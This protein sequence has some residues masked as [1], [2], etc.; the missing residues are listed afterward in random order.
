MKNFVVLLAASALALTPASHAQ[1]KEPTGANPKLVEAENDS[2]SAPMSELTVA[3]IQ[4]ATVRNT[5]G[6]ELGQVDKV[7]AERS[8]GQIRLVLVSVGGFLGIGDKLVAVPWSALSGAGTDPASLMLDAEKGT[9]T[10]APGVEDTVLTDVAYK[11]WLQWGEDYFSKD[12]AP[13]SSATPAKG[14]SGE[15]KADRAATD[16]VE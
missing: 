5:Q 9:L 1:D 12:R 4:G 14:K 16:G 10:S 2:A 15:M 3:Q 8:T 7:L 6:I 13:A 11:Q